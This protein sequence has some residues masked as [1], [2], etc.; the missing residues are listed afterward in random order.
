MTRAKRSTRWWVTLVL[1][2]TAFAL[3]AAHVV[4][5]AGE[6]KEAPDWILPAATFT[7]VACTMVG[8]WERRSPESGD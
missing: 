3:I 5:D 7:A 4:L 6:S 1:L 8:I 2:A